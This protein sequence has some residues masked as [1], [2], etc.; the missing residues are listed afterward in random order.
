MACGGA[1]AC[2]GH[3]PVASSSHGGRGH[4]PSWVGRRRQE[5]GGRGG[6]GGEACG[7]AL[8]PSQEGGRMGRGHA[9]DRGAACGDG[10]A[11]GASVPRQVACAPS[12]ACGGSGEVLQQ[13][14]LLQLPLPAREAQPG[15]VLSTCSGLSF[16]C[17]E[18]K[19]HR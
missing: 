16:F 6:R 2:G 3:E 15:R 1:D 4:G 10:R 7:L 19:I 14:R 8:R 13:T 5:S 17:G 18:S 12:A 11:S 9:R